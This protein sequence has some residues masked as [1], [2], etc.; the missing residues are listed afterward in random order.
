[1]EDRDHLLVVNPNSNAET[2]AVMARLGGRALAG[3]GLA[4][5]AVTALSG[6]RVITGVADLEASVPHVL[7]RVRHAATSAT[8]GIV[9]AA[10]G[11]PGVAQLRDQTAVPVVGLG[12]ASVRAASLRRRPF[13]MVTSTVDLGPSLR[14]LIARHATA[15]FTGLRFTASPAHLLDADDALTEHELREAI[16]ACIHGDG[17]ETVIVGGGPLSRAAERIGRAHAGRIVEPVPSAV[18]YLLDA[19]GVP[20]VAV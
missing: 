19:L 11:D 14:A 18:A 5:R 8:R 13:G 12:E 16:G 15:P 10:I 17:A 1:M 4:V 3:T 20:A 7:E 6:P 9:V 2:T